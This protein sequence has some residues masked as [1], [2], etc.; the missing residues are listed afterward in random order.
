MEEVGGHDALGL[1]RE[2]PAPGWTLWV[3]NT[4]SGPSTWTFVGVILATKTELARR[5]LNWSRS[6]TDCSTRRQWR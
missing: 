6:V 5:G 1:G 3:P 2:K 4:S